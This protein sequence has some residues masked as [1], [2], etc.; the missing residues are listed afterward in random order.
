MESKG[1]VDLTNQLAKAAAELRDCSVKLQNI[2]LKI[3]NAYDGSRFVEHSIL[4]NQKTELASTYQ[5]NLNYILK[6]IDSHLDAKIKIYEELSKKFSKNSNF[7][8]DNIWELFNKFNEWLYSLS[9]QENLAFVNLSG[10]ILI[11]LSL[12]SIIMIFYGDI[13]LNYFQLEERFPRI[14]KLIILRRKFQQYYLLIN[15]LIISVVLI[16][17]F[18]LNLLVLI[19]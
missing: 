10:I 15:I 11:M 8:G 13:I 19:H 7:I 12:F 5:K 18:A 4:V 17:M 6:N 3:K 16:I 2:E 14:A 1:V 9:L